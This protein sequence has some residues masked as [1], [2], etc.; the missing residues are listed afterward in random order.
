MLDEVPYEA[1]LV[2]FGL[3]FG[4]TNDPTAIVG[5]YYYNGG[6]ILDEVIYQKGLSNKDIADILNLQGKA[7][8]VADSAEPKS[9]DEIKSYGV[10]VLPATKGA[11][12]ITQ[13]IQYIQE[14]KISVTKRSTNLWKEYNNYLW[15]T[16]KDGKILNVPQDFLNHT[17]D[18]IRYGFDKINPQNQIPKVI[19]QNNFNQW[20][21]S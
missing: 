8:C 19:P 20:T 13:G 5:I 10:I 1:R 11:G 12:S 16:D 15:V 4:Y 9:I 7:T 17:M 6:Y 21:I 18:A 14:Q 2:R 3:D